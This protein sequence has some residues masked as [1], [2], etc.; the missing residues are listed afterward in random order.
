LKIAVVEDNNKL[1]ASILKQ[2][3][4]TVY[5]QESGQWEMLSRFENTVYKA[6]EIAEVRKAVTDIVSK[7]DGV[8]IIIA[9]ELPGVAHSIFKDSG[10]GIFLVENNATDI[11][12]AAIEE[13]SRVMEE[14]QKKTREIDVFQ[15][16]EHGMAKG[17]YY[18]N[19][20]E[21]MLNYPQLTSKSLLL[22]Y[23]KDGTFKRLDVICSHIPPWFDK[24]FDE[25]GFVYET[26]NVLPDKTT[27]RIVHAKTL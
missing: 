2:G 25:L 1:T 9:S 12:D 17:D 16:F 13:L 6:S 26:V 21:V 27:V 10:L 19:M 3:F 22:P 5:T 14:Q 23:L 11:L 20:I 15:L 4:I 7:L 24:D 8:T 18:V